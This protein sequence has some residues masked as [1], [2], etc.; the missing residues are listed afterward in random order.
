[1]FQRILVGLKDT[2]ASKTGFNYAVK[3]AREERAELHV[4]SVGSIPEISATTTGEVHAAE[5]EARS[6]LVPLL[7]TARKTAELQGQP[8]LT[9][10]RFGHVADV[11]TAYASEHGINLIVLGKR[12]QHLGAT[13]ERIITHAPCPVFVVSESEII[14]FT[15]PADHRQQQWEIRKDLR[16]R[17]EGRAQML[18][19]FI[20][21]DDQ[22]GGKPLYEAIVRRLREA[23]I[24]GATAYRGIMGYGAQ[25]RLHKA[26]FLK[27]STD[28]PMIIT[29]VDTE[30]N[31]RRIITMLDEMVDEGLIVLSNVEVIKY[32][33]THP[34][35]DVA[36]VIPQRRSTD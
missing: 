25:Q 1:M 2:Q 8:I 29:V 10:L 24:A 15:G 12:Q 21:E 11:I 16:Q 3:L 6:R 20:G 32:V 4:V 5:E 17:L 7:K 28:L 14:K 33:H 13:G 23:D 34:E 35:L 27:L 22:W 26:G 19:I 18:R 31:M 36:A 30:E 9:E